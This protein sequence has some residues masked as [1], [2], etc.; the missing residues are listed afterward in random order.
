MYN[1]IYVMELD[2]NTLVRVFLTKRC[3]TIT[4][5]AKLMSEK[6]GKKISQQNLS[7]K[8]KTGILKYDE[9]LI[10]AKILGFKI[11]IEEE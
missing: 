5:L 6:T 2:A 7:N 11:N 10:I 8:L 1:I 9:M 4:K 3:M